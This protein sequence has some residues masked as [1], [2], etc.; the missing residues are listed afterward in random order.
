[1]FDFVLIDAP[2][3][4]KKGNSKGMRDAKIA[5]EE[6][7][8]CAGEA[9]VI[10]ID[11]VHRRHVFDTIEQFSIQFIAERERQKIIEQIYRGLVPGG[12]FLVAEKTVSQCAKL[13]EILTC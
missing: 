3:R 7:R 2:N 12:A 9:D 11:D 4:L 8:R 5:M 13:H 10:M 1:V 6:L